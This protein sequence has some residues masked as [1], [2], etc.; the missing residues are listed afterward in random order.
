MGVQG[1][2]THVRDVLVVDDESS[3]R[4]LCRVN[5]ELEGHAVREASTLAEARAELDRAVPDVVLLDLHIGID[6]GLELLDHIEALELPTRV[7]LLS[8]S[9][10]IKQ[11]LRNRVDSVLGKPFSLG[12]LSAAVT[13]SIVR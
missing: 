10:E 3:L 11:E 4:L 9:A 13:G 12:R 8:G 5:L 7:V 2:R 6:D 1:G